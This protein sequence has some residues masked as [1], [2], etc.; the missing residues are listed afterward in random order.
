M[1]QRSG[2]TDVSDSSDVERQVASVGLKVLAAV[3]PWEL[4]YYFL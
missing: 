2:G 4:L 1:I 3:K